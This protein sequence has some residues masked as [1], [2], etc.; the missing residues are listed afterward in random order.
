MTTESDPSVAELPLEL[1]LSLLLLL[2]QIG[3]EM[4]TGSKSQVRTSPLRCPGQ[5]GAAGLQARGAPHPTTQAAGSGS[6]GQP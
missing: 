5:A 1:I 6:G 4:S 3:V 2:L